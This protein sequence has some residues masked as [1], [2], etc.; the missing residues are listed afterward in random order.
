MTSTKAGPI[1]RLLERLLIA[2]GV[3]WLFAA[4]TLTLTA[5]LGPVCG[6]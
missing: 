1:R 6:R 5:G 4:A 3:A 2:G